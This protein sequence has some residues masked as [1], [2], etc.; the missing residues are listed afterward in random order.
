[1]LVR[2]KPL[3]PSEMS[4]RMPVALVVED[5]VD[6]C[7]LIRSHLETSGHTV[8]Q[9]FDGLTALALV[10]QHA[11]QIIILDWMLPGMDGLEVCRQIRRA[12]LMP[13]IMLTA[14]SEEIDRVLGLEVGADDYVVKPFSLRELMAR[15]RAL[16]RRVE[17]D[18]QMGQTA[19]GERDLASADEATAIAL[20]GLRVD[21]ITH[22]A[23]LD[24]AA[25][26]LTPREFD[27]LNLFAAHPRRAFSRE[28]LVEQLW[29][30]DYD[31]VDRTV[32]THVTRLRK[33]LGRL[34]EHIVTVW[35]V[36][37]RFVP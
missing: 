34:G 14:R 3:S 36:G 27:L 30:Y 12:H 7:N 26:D 20:G 32:D 35:G 16:L 22:E 8:Y 11:P 15:V 25:L 28:Y 23:I 17:L 1:M 6:M 18:G 2:D 4:A 37:Y 9:A 21:P 29:G 24:G 5:D 33:K 19:P 13:I 31:G 10:E